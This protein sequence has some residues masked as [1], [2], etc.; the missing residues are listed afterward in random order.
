MDAK[1]REER[2]QRLE[3][4][5]KIMEEENRRLFGYTKEDRRKARKKKIKKF[6][7]RIFFTD[8]SSKRRKW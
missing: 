4:D 7:K 2:I 1:E 8:I 6:F 5:V 3:E